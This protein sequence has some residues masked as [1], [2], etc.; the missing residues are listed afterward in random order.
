MMLIE[1]T[2]PKHVDGDRPPMPTSAARRT[3]MS[4]RVR[5]RQCWLAIALG[6]VS[7]VAIG[8]GMAVPMES[9]EPR[10]ARLPPIDQGMPIGTDGGMGQAA[11]DQALPEGNDGGLPSGKGV[12]RL[13][14]VHDHWHSDWIGPQA[15]NG[16]AVGTDFLPTPLPAD[17]SYFDPQA[18]QQIYDGRYSVP[19]QRP[20]IEWGR[21][22]YDTGLLPPVGD[23]LGYT[24]PTQPS[25]FLY[26]DY[27]TGI[28]G[29]D[30]GSADFGQWAHR[31]NLD[32]DYWITA[33]ERFHAFVGPLNRANEFTHV[34]F[35]GNDL[36]FNDFINFNPVTAFFEGDAGNLWGGATNQMQP[37]DLPFTVGLVPLL[38]Q[39][40]IWMEDAVTGAA[41]A[42]PAQHW[43]A[44][45]WSNFDATFFAAFDQVNSPAFGQ[46]NH[47][48]QIF[49]TAWFIEAYQGYIEA[50]YAFLNDR[51]DLGRSYHNATL[52]FTK[53]YFHTISN[54]ARVIVNFGQDLP[55]AERTADGALVLI[56]NSLMTK[57]PYTVV[58]YINF[59]A[60]FDRPQSV[61]RAGVS[62]GVLRNTGINFEIDGLTSYPTLD[63]TANNT[64]GSA[65]GLNW[66]G[67]NFAHQLVT[68]VAFLDAFGDPS[69]RIARGDQI[70]LGA[71]YQQPLTHNTLIRADTIYGFREDDDN[72]WGLRLE[73]RYKF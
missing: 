25:F 4:F 20:W 24:N 64:W 67:D 44:L 57:K 41:F 38:Y 26:G 43:N 42:I 18:Q 39:N 46:D 27:R 16:P 55:E 61:A 7:S 6:L 19:V 36:Q 15:G 34:D 1:R 73:W 31:L 23:E 72:L 3:R 66:L 13:P 35:V 10:A 68:E 14:P 9:I 8:Q 12:R 71:R 59:F 49:G 29:G 37:F 48:A 52:S 65:V 17:A 11:N 30:T 2:L 21:P 40:G 62:G 50:G 22:F 53:R 63:A 32:F 70:A 33:T 47:A 56:E 5:W 60:G 28:A 51:Q 54:S 69:L 58:P 45:G